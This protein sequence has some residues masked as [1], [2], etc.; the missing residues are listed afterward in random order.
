MQKHTNRLIVAAVLIA[1]GVIGGFFVVAAHRRLAA[2]DA[3]AG[4]VTRRIEQMR[5]TA[6][7]IAAAQQAYVAPGQPDQPWLE[8]SAMLL[9]E[10][11]QDAAA[12]RP[13]LRSTDAAAALDE[14]EKDF[15]AIVV[16]D[17]TARQDLQQEQSLLAADLIFSEGHDTIA[18]L[19]MTLRGLESAEAQTVA[20]Q[21]ASLERQQAGAL[22]VI[23]VILIAGIL[24]L[25]RVPGSGIGDPGSVDLSNL[26]PP[27]P[28]S[29][30][31]DPGLAA[32]A[33]PAT[34]DLQAAADICGALAR[35]TNTVALRDALAQSA[36][37]L[38]ARGIIV[39]MGA[40]EELF[41][42]LSFGYDER[43]VQ[44]LGPIPRN[45]ANA[46]A[47]AWRTAQLRTVSADVTARGAVAAPI[48]GVSGCVG[49]FA[50]E[51]RNGREE[52]PATRAVAA[53]IAAQLAGIV[54][55]WPAASSTEVPK[56]A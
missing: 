45:A 2:I 43:V 34:V 48:N 11:G 41:P 25:A 5:T 35:T 27:D 37:V 26:E 28:G 16:I 44:R 18:A 17:G 29:R 51:V 6:G 9:Q 13:L 42:A 21:R 50:A 31:P 55:A 14:V 30:I 47:E 38:N 24:W 12:I 3:A 36:A 33:S 56:T 7:D 32:T 39:W 10:F 49:V 19:V 54:S 22:A 20:A 15:K 23:G 1:A 46:T 4:D 52:D 53:I 40:G 8:R